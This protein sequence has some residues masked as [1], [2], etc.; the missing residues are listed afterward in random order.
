MN[1]AR[2]VHHRQRFH[3][4]LHELDQ[5]CRVKNALGFQQR[6]EGIALEI[7]HHDIG[8]IVRL[9]GVE[10]IHNAVLGR[11]R[12]KTSR[13]L[14]K[15]FHAP[16]VHGL[17]SARNNHIARDDRGAVRGAG[18]IKLLDRHTLGEHLV[19]SDI[20]DAKAALAEHAANQIAVLQHCAGL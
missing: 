7:F 8:G 14:H 12:R 1:K 16:A 18:R 15:A 13:F 19:K 3:H 5:L 17:L 20:G 11:E 10:H 4:R 9:K 2:A 6:L